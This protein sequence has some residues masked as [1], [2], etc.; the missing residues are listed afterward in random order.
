MVIEKGRSDGPALRI[1]TFRYAL[2]G[3]RS[4][5]ADCVSVGD[6]VE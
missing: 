6:S 5:S 1:D 3:P 4:G 2:L